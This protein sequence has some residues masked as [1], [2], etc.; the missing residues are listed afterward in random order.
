MKTGYSLLSKLTAVVLCVVV[1]PLAGF[2]QGTSSSQSAGQI[3]AVVPQATRNGNIAKAREEVMWGDL[4]RTEPSGRARVQLRDGSILSLGSGSELRIAQHDANTQQTDLE[5][6]YGRVRSRVVQLTKPGA[7]F[8][9]K[10]GTAVAGVVGTDFIVIFEA[11]R[12]QVI[13]FSGI[14]QIVG[15]NGAIMATVNPGQMV[16]IVNGVVNGPTQTPPG[17]QQDAINQTN[18]NGGQAT[19]TGAEGGSLLKT[20]LIAIGVAATAAVITAVTTN[21]DKERITST[22]TFCSFCDKA[23]RNNRR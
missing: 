10:T 20:V 13:V 18:A 19:T 17:V 23:V 6:N 3:T 12:M 11:G 7:R 2:A 1:S 15:I 8:Q 21:R 16:E 22:P 14:V 9:V 5:L 4:L